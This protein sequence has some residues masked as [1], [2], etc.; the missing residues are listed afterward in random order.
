LLEKIK[1]NAFLVVGLFFLWQGW[2]GTQVE[3]PTEEAKDELRMPA[4]RASYIREGQDQVDG[5]GDGVGAQAAPRDPFGLAKLKLAMSQQESAMAELR[6]HDGGYAE[7]DTVS[8]TKHALN[9][10]STMN[11]GGVWIARINGHTLRVGDQLPDFDEENPPVL[12]SVEGMI[13]QLRYNGLLVTLD[14][15]GEASVSVE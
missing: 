13:A 5:E 11:A 7:V 2:S 6:V 9:L 3:E 14:L 15:T 8:K 4:I 10:Q 12:V 1:R